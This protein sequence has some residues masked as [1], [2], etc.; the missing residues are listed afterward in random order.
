[1]KF[2]YIKLDKL[3][4]LAPVI[5]WTT[6]VFLPLILNFIEFTH[7]DI[8]YS[9]FPIREWT[10]NSLIEYKELPLW[11]P[12]EGIGRPNIK[13][14]MY[15]FDILS[16]LI[17]FKIVNPAV[18]IYTITLIFN[19]IVFIFIRKYLSYYISLICLVL[20]Y[21]LPS[22]TY[23]RYYYFTNFNFIICIVYLKLYIDFYKGITYK[24]LYAIFLAII[25]FLLSVGS[26][27]ELL[28][29][30][31]I[32]LITAV[33]CCVILEKRA[34][35]I[36]FKNI[37]KVLFFYIIILSPYIYYIRDAASNSLRASEL[38]TV[39][40]F[41]NFFRVI[42]DISIGFPSFTLFFV[43]CIN[44]KYSNN[45]FKYG[46]SLLY[47]ILLG[48]YSN[49]INYLF[50]LTYVTTYLMLKVLYKIQWNISNLIYFLVFITYFSQQIPGPL[51][52]GLIINSQTL[53]FKIILY[54]LMS[55]IT[56][57]NDCKVLRLIAILMSII[58]I[59]RTVLS[60]L[61]HYVIKLAWYP[62]RDTYLFE[63]CIAVIITISLGK[64]YE[65]IGTYFTKNNFINNF[66]HIIKRS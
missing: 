33:I 23:L 60:V 14:S 27:I 32:F 58:F 9:Y 43:I 4:E 17:F 10:F 2:A 20:I 39:D 36:V 8:Y 53:Q 7:D 57:I 5:I 65:E 45:I 11:N 13:W 18:Y 63:L 48:N 1:M 19:L 66:F 40:Y 55:Y 22:I 3:L 46:I 38:S 61:M 16:P 54:F 31:N 26:K 51:N 56:I 25:L 34:I 15:P 49:N 12:Y 59:F 21:S 64:L 35:L 28:I 29:Y 42:F 62:S 37:Y 44:L 47:L 6:V 52:D 30:S 41:T 50:I 24:N